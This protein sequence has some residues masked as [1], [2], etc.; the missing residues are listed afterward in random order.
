[1]VRERLRLPGLAIADYR[2]IRRRLNGDV[3][4]GKPRIV[5]PCLQSLVA[6]TLQDP[7]GSESD[8]NRQGHP[9]PPC[10]RGFG[11]RVRSRDPPARLVSGSA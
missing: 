6:R 10:R 9:P 3:Q 1:V 2:L 8:R 4:V 11:R 5:E 7:T